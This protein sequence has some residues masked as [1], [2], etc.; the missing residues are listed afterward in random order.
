MKRLI[1][2]AL[3]VLAIVSLVALA[4][5]ESDYDRSYNFAALKS[6]DFKVQTRMP[7]DPVG[8]NT[9]WNRRIREGLER[10]LT[11]HGFQHV[12]DGEPTFLVAYYMGTKQKYDVRYIN[13]GLP[14]VWHRWGR[15]GGWGP[16]W[17]GDVDVWKIP[18][19]ESTMVLDIIDPKSNTLVWRGYDTRTIDFDKSDKTIKK[20][21]DN[22]MERFVEDIEENEED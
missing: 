7:T 9:L 10:E 2:L 8:T 1:L 5:T 17:S 22:L 16:G 12:K 18:Y 21:I 4:D 11:A 13:Y 3:P 20:A 15:W 14:G 19:T 6:W